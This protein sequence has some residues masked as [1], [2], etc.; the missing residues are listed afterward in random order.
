MA[1]VSTESADR[2]LPPF[3]LG[4]AGGAMIALSIVGLVLVWNREE[5]SELKLPATPP[6]APPA[7]SAPPVAPPAGTAAGAPA[8]DGARE[9][10]QSAWFAAQLAAAEAEWA[11]QLELARAGAGESQRAA[12]LALDEQHLAD[13]ARER[14]QHAAELAQLRAELDAAVARAQVLAEAPVA[15]PPA[16][17]PPAAAAEPAVAQ[18]PPAAGLLERAAS[19]EVALALGPFLEPGYA[20]LD[21]SFGQVELPFSY[22][23]LS[24][25]GALRPTPEGWRTLYKIA[26][27]RRDRAR[28]RWAADPSAENLA[29]AEQA[30]ALLVELGPALVELGK[31]RP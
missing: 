27:S 9:A 8:A 23:Q 28:T 1:T 6:A 11:K 4:L 25:T 13:L 18:A 15:A 7:A 17:P 19:P 24:A 21:N 14:E 26:S 3:F 12:L 22:S 2:R 29:A 5:A 10:D 16:D 20:Q 30:Q 31:M